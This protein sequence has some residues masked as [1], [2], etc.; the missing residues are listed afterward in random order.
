MPDNVLQ[1]LTWNEV[2]PV[3]LDAF[4]LGNVS[5]LAWAKLAWENLSRVE[6]TVYN[7]GMDRAQIGI[8][9]LALADIYRDFYYIMWEECDDSDYFEWA[10][11]LEIS[12]FRVGQLVGL[13]PDFDDGDDDIAYNYAVRQLTSEARREVVHNLS[14]AFKGKRELF[15]S[16]LRS[17]KAGDGSEN[18][19]YSPEADLDNWVGAKLA[20]FEW[21]EQGCPPCFF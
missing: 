3:A 21:L 14:I 16:L 13:N 10:E 6:A 2:L 7:T 5:G 18:G 9:F 8:H 1:K 20:A 4:D 17:N 19:H 11:G 12:Q 15:I